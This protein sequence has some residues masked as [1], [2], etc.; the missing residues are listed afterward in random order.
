MNLI[1][2]YKFLDIVLIELGVRKE[3]AVELLVL[4]NI[5]MLTAKYC[6]NNILWRQKNL[7]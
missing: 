2:H 1:A 6:K 3:G 4:L 7:Y 5:A